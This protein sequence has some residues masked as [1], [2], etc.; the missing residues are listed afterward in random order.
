MESHQNSKQIF[1]IILA[2]TFIAITVKNPLIPKREKI[3]RAKSSEFFKHAH[4]K[5]ETYMF[6]LTWKVL[7]EKNVFFAFKDFLPQTTYIE[8]NVNTQ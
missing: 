5:L 7:H 6:V 8:R 4:D 1:F 3:H 2:T